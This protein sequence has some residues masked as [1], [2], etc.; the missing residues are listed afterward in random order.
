MNEN[1]K[2]KNTQVARLLSIPLSV[3]VPVVAVKK[4]FENFKLIS[5]FR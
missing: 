1:T 3:A 5:K 2:T 4:E